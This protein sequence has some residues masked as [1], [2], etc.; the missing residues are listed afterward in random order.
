MPQGDTRYAKGR[1][2]VLRGQSEEVRRRHH[3]KQWLECVLVEGRGLQGPDAGRHS[4]PCP[5][6]TG[7]MLL[8]TWVTGSG[9]SRG[10]LCTSGSWGAAGVKELTCASAPCVSRGPR[11]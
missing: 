4:G 10:H 5:G 2:A 9:D 8:G 11:W 1:G 3:G 6:R 7:N